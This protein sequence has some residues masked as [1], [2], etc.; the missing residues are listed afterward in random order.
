MLSNLHNRDSIQR[1]AAKPSETANWTTNE[2][3]SYTVTLT[4][5]E[6]DRKINPRITDRR[7]IRSCSDSNLSLKIENPARALSTVRGEKSDPDF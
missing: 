2:N 3:T 7:R 1:P 5:R 4:G 6:Y